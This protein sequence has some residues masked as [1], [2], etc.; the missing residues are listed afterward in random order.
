MSLMIVIMQR[1]TT[2]RAAHFLR[3]FVRSEQ[4]RLPIKH[5]QVRPAT[6]FLAV[7]S[8]NASRPSGFSSR[9]IMSSFLIQ[10]RWGHAA[11]WRKRQEVRRTVH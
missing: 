5:E 10:R 3:N 11:G 7:E 8:T 9:I 6:D 2:K 1:G 4:V